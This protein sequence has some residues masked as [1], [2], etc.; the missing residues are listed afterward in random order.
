MVTVIAEKQTE[1]NELCARFGVERL[2]VFGSA[3]T[4]DQFDPTRSDVDFIVTFEASQDLGPWL[5]HYL[6]FRDELI[7]LLGYPVDLVMSSAMRNPYF[8]REANRTRR[9]LYGA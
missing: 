3:A 7:N 1:L 4:D 6:D 8:V 2:E 9:L 5:Q